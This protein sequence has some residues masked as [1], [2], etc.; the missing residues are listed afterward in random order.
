MCEA[1]RVLHHLRN[2][3]ADSRNT[4]LLTGYQAENTLGRKLEDGMEER[5]DLW[6]AGAGTARKSSRSTNSAATPI[7]G[8]CWPG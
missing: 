4:V 6:H 3:I 2:N 1:G 7:R 8:N 5:A